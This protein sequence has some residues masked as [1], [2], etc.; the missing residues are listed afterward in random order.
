MLQTLLRCARDESLPWFWRSVCLE[1]V[2]LSLA[3]LT[4]LLGG[5]E[6][7]MAEAFHARVFDARA[8]LPVT[9]G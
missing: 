7:L 6:S 2:N 8:A 1:N 5:P 3:K 4:T 9:P